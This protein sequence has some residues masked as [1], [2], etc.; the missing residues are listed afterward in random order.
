MKDKPNT[1]TPSPPHHHLSTHAPMHHTHA[2][3]HAP[4]HARPSLPVNQNSNP[5][6]ANIASFEL[7]YTAAEQ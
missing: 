7:H 2:L 1:S 4:T 5:T 3:T 6:P